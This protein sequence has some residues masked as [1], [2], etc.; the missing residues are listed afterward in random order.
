MKTFWLALVIAC[1]MAFAAMAQELPG[2]TAAVR[3]DSA[4]MRNVEL[5]ELVVK[6]ALVEHTANGDTYRVTER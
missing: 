3:Q 6:G 4:A 1:P 2:D 5:D